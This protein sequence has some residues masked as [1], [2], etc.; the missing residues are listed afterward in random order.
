[1]QKADSLVNSLL[2]NTNAPIPADEVVPALRQALS[3]QQQV[4]NQYQGLVQK[5]KATGE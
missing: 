5:P 2:P 1:V 3:E 4:L